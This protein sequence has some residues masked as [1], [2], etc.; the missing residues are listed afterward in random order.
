MLRFPKWRLIALRCKEG[1]WEVA[2]IIL[3]LYHTAT[4]QTCSERV[5]T[6]ALM[7]CHDNF[8]VHEARWIDVGWAETYISSVSRGR[9]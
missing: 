1:K 9:Y 3:M 8:D 7:M 2:S 4:E 5:E 6:F